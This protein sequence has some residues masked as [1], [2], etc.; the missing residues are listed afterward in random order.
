MKG[1]CP[2]TII[3]QYASI[4]R[5]VI[6]RVISTFLLRRAYVKVLIQAFNLTDIA[7]I[8]GTLPGLEILIRNR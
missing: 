8:Y 6:T 7:S 2:K 4:A 5:I 3:N 1:N